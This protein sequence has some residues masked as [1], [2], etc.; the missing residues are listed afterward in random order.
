MSKGDYTKD[1]KVEYLEAQ[2]CEQPR[3]LTSLTG[4]PTLRLN[5]N[6]YRCKKGLPQKVQSFGN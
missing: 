3:D 6:T 5:E 4:G 2:D 1:V